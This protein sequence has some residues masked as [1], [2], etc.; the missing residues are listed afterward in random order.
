HISNDPAAQALIASEGFEKSLQR[1][2]GSVKA[3]LDGWRIFE[4]EDIAVLD[5]GFIFNDVF[6]H[7]S[8]LNLK[9]HA[10][11]PLPHDINV[12]IGPNGSGNSRVL[13]QMV[14]DWISPSDSTE[15]GFVAKPNLSQ[16]VVVSYSPFERFP[17]DLQGRP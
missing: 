3:Y 17:V 4:R 1:E 15:T 7:T 6:G 11:N 10:A 8:T 5:L 16:L 9:F 2:R 13:H 12:L 14:E